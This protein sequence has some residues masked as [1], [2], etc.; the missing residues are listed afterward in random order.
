MSNPIKIVDINFLKEFA[1]S[2]EEMLDIFQIFIRSTDGSI[3]DL[4]KA[5]EQQNHEKWIETAHKLKGSSAMIGATQLRDASSFAQRMPKTTHELYVQK[6]SEIKIL[7][8]ETKAE[9]KKE[10]EIIE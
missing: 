5:I 9:L 3:S 6:L 7:L 10:I 8:D 2:K 4:E 1:D